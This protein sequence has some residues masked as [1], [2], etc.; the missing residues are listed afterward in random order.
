VGIEV[1]NHCAP[2]ALHLV[3]KKPD[4]QR[5]VGIDTEATAAIRATVVKPATEIDRPSSLHRQPCCLS[6]D[7]HTNNT[8]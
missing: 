6:V 1:N 3:E 8:A 2:D 4:R 7:I 5:D